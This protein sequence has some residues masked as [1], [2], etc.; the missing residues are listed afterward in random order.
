M[1]SEMYFQ[2]NL[3]YQKIHCIST[4]QSLKPEKKCIII[5]IQES[6]TTLN[7]LYLERCMWIT[8]WSMI[9]QNWMYNSSPVYQI[10][11]NIPRTPCIAIRKSQVLKE[12][13]HPVYVSVCEWQSVAWLGRAGLSRAGEQHW[14]MMVSDQSWT[15]HRHTQIH[16]S[17]QPGEYTQQHY[18]INIHKY[19]ISLFL[20]LRS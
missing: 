5:Y 13:E 7:T 19:T 9:G 17:Q 18:F 2:D 20:I 11:S 1:Q 8:E 4:R 16:A 10:I 12:T 3:R 15:H 14:L 6:Q